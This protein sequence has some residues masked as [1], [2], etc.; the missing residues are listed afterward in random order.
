MEE[1][2]MIEQAHTRLMAK[3]ATDIANALAPYII[4]SFADNKK[5]STKK[6]KKLLSDELEADLTCG[7]TKKYH[8]GGK[9]Y[10]EK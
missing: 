6:A 2:E 7:L 9:V 3:L 10:M 5:A 1:I 8:V 4:S